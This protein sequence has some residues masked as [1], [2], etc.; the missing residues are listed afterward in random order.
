MRDYQIF[1]PLFLSRTQVKGFRWYMYFGSEGNVNTSNYSDTGYIYPGTGT[2][3]AKVYLDGMLLDDDAT[4]AITGLPKANVDD[5]CVFNLQGQYLGRR[6]KLNLSAG[7]Y[8][9]NGKKV[10]VK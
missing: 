7:V 5:D 8:I 1:K 2:V 6:S 9:M 3:Y 4:T 10:R